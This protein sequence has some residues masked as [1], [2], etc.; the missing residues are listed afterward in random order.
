MT[1]GTEF[2]V[3][4]SFYPPCVTTYVDD[5]DVAQAADSSVPRNGR[6][7]RARG[8]VPRLRRTTAA[9]GADVEMTEYAGA[10]HGF[11]NPTERATDACSRRLIWIG[12]VLAL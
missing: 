7:H 11:D 10:Q 3:Y 4:I 9:A 12:S 8:A 6:R 2:A 5:V 1:P